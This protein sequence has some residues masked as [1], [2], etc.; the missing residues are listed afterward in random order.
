MEDAIELAA[1]IVGDLVWLA[2]MCILAWMFAPLFFWLW[3]PFAIL[4]GLAGGVLFFGGIAFV[5]AWPV[6]RVLGHE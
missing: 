5:H 6:P 2:I 4:L 3:E 1:H